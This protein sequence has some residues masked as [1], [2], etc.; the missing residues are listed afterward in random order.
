MIEGGDEPV[1]SPGF[2]I[3]QQQ[4]KD[5]V[6]RLRRPDA[7]AP[8]PY[9]DELVPSVSVA[10]TSLGSSG[11]ATHRIPVVPEFTALTNSSAARPIGRCWRCDARQR[12]GPVV[13][14]YLVA[15]ADGDHTF[16][17]SADT[18]AFLR[19][20]DAM[21]IDADFGYVSGT[22]LNGTIKLKAGL[23]PF[24]LYYARGPRERPP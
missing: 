2:A 5:R 16:Y 9:D 23:H 4:M 8:R 11:R 20:H 15:P 10:A 3:L 1:G 17:L 7:S 24:R 12:R 19:I 22:E 18:G 14:G 13:H 6:L 21:V